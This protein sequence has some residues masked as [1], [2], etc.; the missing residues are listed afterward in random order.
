MGAGLVA[1]LLAGTA[2]GLGALPVLVTSELSRKAQGPDVGL[3]RGRDAGGQSFSLVIPA[4]ELVRGQGHDGPSAALRVAA[5]VLL[6]GLFL[7]VWHDLMPH[8]HALKGHEGHGG[9]KWNSALLFVLAMTLHNFPE[10]LAV[11]VSF[12]APQPELGLSVALGIGAQ[13]IPEGLVV[14]LALRA[15]GASASRA[16]FLALLTGMVEPV[17]ALFG[18][19]ALSL[20]SAL[21]PWGLAFA[22]GAML[23]VIS[24]E[25][26]PESHRGGFEREA[27]TGLMW[28][29]V[30][31][32]VLDMSLG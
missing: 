14:A 10:G 28:G 20:S 24:H 19:L 13:N 11:G 27:T 32:L 30:L 6:G 22:G 25:M 23:Y 8:E 21:L 5:G 29:F 4:M 9:T 18:V 7:R 26:I 2:T 1:S 12:A 17:G 3:Q 15:S 16:A 31:A